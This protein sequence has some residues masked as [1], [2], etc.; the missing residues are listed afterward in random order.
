LPDPGDFSVKNCRILDSGHFSK[1][2]SSRSAGLILFQEA[3]KQMTFDQ[4]K[5]KK[6]TLLLP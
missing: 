5:V 4:A 2:S 3:T 6:Q 1:K